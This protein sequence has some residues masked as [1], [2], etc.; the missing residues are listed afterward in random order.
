[1][2]HN[3]MS[4]GSSIPGSNDMLRID[5]SRINEYLYTDRPKTSFWK[6]LGQGFGKVFSFMAPI[7]A[8]VTAAVVPGFG[9]PLAAGIYGLGKLSNDLTANS[10]AKQNA[11]MDAYN[12]QVSQMQV[13]LPGLFEQA[14]EVDYQL[15]FIAKPELNS[16]LIPTLGNR[17]VSGTY[18]VENFEFF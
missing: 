9:I 17:E 14:S 15:D 13:T 6:K 7:G 1:M 3:I 12:Q 8:A 10:Y 18:Q 2:G 4:S 16:N 11:E 5:N